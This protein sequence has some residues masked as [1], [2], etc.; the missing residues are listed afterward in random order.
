M[1]KTETKEDQPELDK[2]VKKMDSFKVNMRIM[3][4]DES[5]GPGTAY[6]NEECAGYVSIERGD[7]EEFYQ[8]RDFFMV[9]DEGEREF[10]IYGREYKRPLYK[11]LLMANIKNTNYTK[12]LYLT[13]NISIPFKDIRDVA[14]VEADLKTLVKGMSDAYGLLLNTKV[15][16][17]TF[18]RIKDEVTI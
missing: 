5:E 16:H 4:N 13:E 8:I 9:S 10:V 14:A 18:E 3:P 7:N 1:D 6:G 17:Y 2:V 15:I 12:D 11:G